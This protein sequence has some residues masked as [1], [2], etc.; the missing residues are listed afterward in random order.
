[1]PTTRKSRILGGP[2]SKSGQKTLTFNG[3]HKVTKPIPASAKDTK[4]T[5]SPVQAKKIADEVTEID[6][7]SITSEKAIAAQAEVEKK[8][9]KRTPEEE[10][11]LKVSDA[12]IKRYW[13]AR[14]EDRLAPRV[15]QKGL[16]VEEK[17]LR[18][19]D[20]TSTYGVSSFLLLSCE[21]EHARIFAN[22]W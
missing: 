7:G 20:I 17:I 16:S 1:M 8:V 15:H 18:L 21:G 19:F 11:A 4:T 9:L 13:K 2:T 12:Q 6:V 10:K 14:E 5:I 22:V 3:Q